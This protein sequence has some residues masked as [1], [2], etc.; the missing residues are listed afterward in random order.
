M[1]YLEHKKRTLSLPQ[2][3]KLYLTSVSI[4]TLFHSS[5]HERWAVICWA[6]SQNTRV[7]QVNTLVV[8]RSVQLSWCT[9][10]LANENAIWPQLY[11][12]E[13]LG[14]SLGNI[15]QAP[16]TLVK[17]IWDIPLVPDLLIQSTS[18]PIKCVVFQLR[19][20]PQTSHTAYTHYSTACNN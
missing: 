6:I 3:G 10:Q 18:L 13:Q 12:I 11:C 2:P 16:I 5:Y 15:L 7:Y 17:S 19:M 20:H 1:Y 4:E 14:C 8:T 9:T